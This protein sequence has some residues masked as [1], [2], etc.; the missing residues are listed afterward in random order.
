MP[1]KVYLNGEEIV[2]K[3]GSHW[4]VKEGIEGRDLVVDKDFYI[5]VLNPMGE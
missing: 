4:S 1:L 3:P 5:S 2:L